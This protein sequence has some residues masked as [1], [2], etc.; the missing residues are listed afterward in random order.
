MIKN[1]VEFASL[2]NLLKDKFVLADNFILRFKTSIWYSQFVYKLFY[3][4]VFL[5]II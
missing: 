3:S 5:D 1:Y 4:N 2:K